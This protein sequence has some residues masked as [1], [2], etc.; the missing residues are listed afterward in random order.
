MLLC[1]S[2][3]NLDK[4]PGWDFFQ[5]TFQ[6]KQAYATVNTEYSGVTASF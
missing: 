3:Y 4:Y 5:V 1:L 6:T 2:L